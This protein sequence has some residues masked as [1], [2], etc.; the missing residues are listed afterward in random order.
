MPSLKQA[1]IQP[2]LS[3]MRPVPAPV[4]PPRPPLNTPSADPEFSSIA[5]API[6]PVMGTPVDASRQF[7]RQSVSQIRMPPLPAL[8]NIA[9]G[10]QIASHVEPV[11]AAAAAANSTAV[12]AQNT[13]N[14]AIAQSFQG[15]WSSAVDY[16]V[17]ASVDEGG[18][19]YLCILPNS[20]EMPPNA[21]YWTLL[22][23]NTSYS[24]VWSSTTN[25]TTGQVVS[26]SSSLYIALQD[27]LNQDPSSTSGYW[28]LLTAVSVYEGAWSSTT[29]Y[30]VGQTVSYTDGNFYIAISPN[31]NVAPAPTGSSDWVLLG[32]SNTLI[33]A[34]SGSTAYVAGMEVTNGGNIWQALQ[35]TTGNAPPTPPAT[36]VYWQLMG[37][38]STAVV[39]P[40]GSIPPTFNNGFTYTSTTTSITWSWGA[41]TIYRADGTTATIAAGSQAI[42]G[43]GAGLT[44]YFLPYCV[45]NGT[46][47]LTL[48]WVD[49]ANVTFPAVVGA[50]FNGSSGEVTTTLGVT[51]PTTYS[52]E[53][54]V[55][56]TASSGTFVELNST[57]GTGA[58]SSTL[59]C[60]LGISGSSATLTTKS[61]TALNGTTDIADGAW[62]HLVILYNG[63]TGQIYV[64][65]VQQTSS[66]ISAP[67]SFTG[68]WRIA[69]GGELSWLNGTVAHVA[70]YQGSE[71]SASQIQNHYSLM[72]T[73]G[74][75]AYAAQ[76][77]AD[78]AT[79]YWKLIETSGTSAADSAGSDTGTYS[80]SVTL[81]QSMGVI[82]PVGS[83]AYAWVNATAQ[84]VQAQS[85][86]T[87]IPLSAGA[88]SA[89]TP[90][91]GSGGG[92]GGGSTGGTGGL[93]VSPDTL[94]RTL[95]GS[96]P[97]SEIQI[98]DV[99]Y[100]ARGTQRGVI[101]I[102]THD[103]SGPMH[104]MPDGLITPTHKVAYGGEWTQARLVFDSWREF[105]G[106]VYN[107]SVESE[108]GDDG[109]TINTEHSYCTSQGLALHNQVFSK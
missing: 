13:A 99:V 6:P 41:I 64:D 30:S 10:S 49:A 84:A 72:V 86:Q 82:A 103:Y 61:S 90:N 83:P 16:V 87:V 88:M 91:T 89:S 33:G 68:Y 29:Q 65:G 81:N 7:Y 40:L 101:E 11:A 94:L 37:P 108:P 24:G 56:T 92:S 19:I 95:R 14:Q 74:V 58:P 43:L 76:V 34:Y 53:A 80:A 97:A 17:G 75:T 25:Y 60:G 4:F 70:V 42:T 20:N 85:L 12:A 67:S 35:A 39:A 38:A 78:G 109:S 9:Q 18:S 79:H 15:A 22:S 21:T 93:C 8:S 23:S 47:S 105:R 1:T 54:W 104:G 31:I 45:D 66:S 46:S 96:L 98:G 36:S 2:D 106:T 63:T 69:E 57:S 62:H 44:Y 107:F 3:K 55:H 32:T 51:Y 71:I 100:T 48:A 102:F 28:Q 5:L 73:S 52:V 59:G 26:E 77:I 27:S 50:S